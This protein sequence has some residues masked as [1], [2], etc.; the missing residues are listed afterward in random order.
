LPFLAL[1]RATAAATSASSSYARGRN[2][3]RARSQPAPSPA[4]STTVFERD[5]WP[6]FAS[7]HRNKSYPH[8]LSD[9]LNVTSPEFVRRLGNASCIMTMPALYMSKRSGLCLSHAAEPAASATGPNSLRMS[10]ASSLGIR[11]SSGGAYLGSMMV[12][13]GAKFIPVRKHAH[14]PRSINLNL[15]GS[16]MI[17][18]LLLCVSTRLCGLMSR[19]TKP[20]R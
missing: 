13:S 20:A 7:R 9:L 5:S 8:L 10:G 2:S 14:A 18:P 1:F 12:S 16:V 11:N 3:D 17:S 19:C 6:L 15:G 4:S